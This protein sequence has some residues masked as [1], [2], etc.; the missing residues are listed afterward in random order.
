MINLLWARMTSV[1][2]DNT[3]Q[4]QIVVYPS[5]YIRHWKNISY[6]KGGW[7]NECS[8]TSQWSTTQLCIK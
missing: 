7:I 3:P 1:V 2:E 6:S 5:F 8:V 4:L